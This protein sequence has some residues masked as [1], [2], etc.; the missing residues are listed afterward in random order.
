MSYRRQKLL[1]RVNWYLQSS[2]KHFTE[3]ITGNKCFYRG[4]RCR[5][6]YRLDWCGIWIESIV[7][8]F[9]ST[10][11]LLNYFLTLWKMYSNIVSYLVC[12]TDKDQIHNGATQHADYPILTI[13]CLLMFWNIPSPASEELIDIPLT[14]NKKHDVD[15]KFNQ[16]VYDV[17]FITRD[18]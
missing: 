3:E 8:S 17:G 16:D 12:L 10:L 4:G 9:I 11:N 2:L 7:W 6:P 1:S 15:N 18:F 14:S 13:P 5:H